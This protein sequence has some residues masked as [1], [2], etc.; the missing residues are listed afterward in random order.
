MKFD[1]FL[2]VYPMKFAEVTLPELAPEEV[3]ELQELKPLQHFTQPPARFT[4]A[5]L[6]KIL[7][8]NGIGRPSTYAPVISTIQ[9]RGYVERYERR[10][11]KP[12]ETGFIV[13][14]LLVEHFPEVVDVAFTAKMEEE[15]DGVAVGK[16]EWQP[17]IREFYEPFAKHLEQK[18]AEVKKHEVTETTEEVCEKC[19]K[20]MVIKLGRFGKF[21]AC[22]GFPDCKNTKTIKQEPQTVDM[23]CQKCGTGDILIR[24]TKRKRIFYGCSRYPECD[25]ASWTDPRKSSEQKTQEK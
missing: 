5:S 16:K 9:E 3:L 14:D 4:E 25:W 18:Y 24:H 13:N 20:P 1:G 10:F 23:K 19:G 6:V 11:L 7:E 22:S 2:K 17:V 8:Q 12:T 15:L 21:L